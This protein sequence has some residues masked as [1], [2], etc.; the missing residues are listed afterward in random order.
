[1]KQTVYARFKSKED[2]FGAVIRAVADELAAF[3]G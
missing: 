1:V 3:G 2:L